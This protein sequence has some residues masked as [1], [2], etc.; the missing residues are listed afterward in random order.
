[1][2][3]TSGV[4]MVSARRKAARGLASGDSDEAYDTLSDALY[5]A[6]ACGLVMTGVLFAC[7]P[8]ALAAICSNAPQVATA[9]STYLN[10]VGPLGYISMI[11]AARDFWRL[12]LRLIQ[13]A[14][15][16]AWSQRSELGETTRW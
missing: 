7:G 1:M 4:K 8:A 14:Q 9:A 6:V 2:K 12:S 3:F 13:L 5:C 11:L 15:Y 10:R 16:R